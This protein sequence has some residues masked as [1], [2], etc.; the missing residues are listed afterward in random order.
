MAGLI[1]TTKERTSII[2]S[3]KR[4]TDPLVFQ[5]PII[6]LVSNFSARK[7]PAP[8]AKL[9]F[10]AESLKIVEFFRE[11]W[12]AEANFRRNGRIEG[13]RINDHSTGCP[14]S[15]RIKGYSL[16]CCWNTRKRIFT[17]WHKKGG[18]F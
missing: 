7:P 16:T 9:D 8:S 6:P 12:R 2:D 10:K 11:I 14:C 1:L 4:S 3:V 17:I 18:L 15:Y 13:S 5:L